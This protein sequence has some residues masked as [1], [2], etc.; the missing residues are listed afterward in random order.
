MRRFSEQALLELPAG[1]VAALTPG[2]RRSVH[3]KRHLQRGLVDSQRGQ[4]LLMFEIADGIGDA[5]V[6]DPANAYNIAGLGNLPLHP[7]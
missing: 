1:Q 3:T 4:R 2:K 7:L 6:G 5:N